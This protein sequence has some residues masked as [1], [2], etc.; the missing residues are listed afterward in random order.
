MKERPIIFSAPMVRAILAGTKTAFGYLQSSPARSAAS[1]GA[2]WQKYE[3]ARAALH[4][5]EQALGPAGS[6]PRREVY[7][8]R[9]ALNTFAAKLR[10]DSDPR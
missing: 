7:V 8:L 1:E 6:E 10:N 2:V 5:L 4:A 9:C 3:A